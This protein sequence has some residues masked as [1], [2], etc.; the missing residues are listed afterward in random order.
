[1]KRILLSAVLSA[2]LAKSAS[3][4]AAGYAALASGSILSAGAVENV[5]IP[6]IIVV[7]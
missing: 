5:I 7:Q 4:I 1:M 2:G 3:W 6:M